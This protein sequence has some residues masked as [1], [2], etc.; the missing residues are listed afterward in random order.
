[1][2][3]ARYDE[4]GYGGKGTGSGGTPRRRLYLRGFRVAI[5]ENSD[6]YRDMRRLAWAI[7]VAVFCCRATCAA[8]EGAA[9]PSRPWTL[10]VFGP[11]RNQ[12]TDTTFHP[13]A[14]PIGEADRIRESAR[15]DAEDRRF[16]EGFKSQRL[17]FYRTDRERR[18]NS[19]I[20]RALSD[21]PLPA[22]RGRM[23]SPQAAEPLLIATPPEAA[24]TTTAENST[25]T[26]P[27]VPTPPRDT[28]QAVDEFVENAVQ[29]ITGETATPPARSAM[30]VLLVVGMF[31]VPASGI[32]FVLI[33]I[34]HLRG[35]SFLPGSIILALGGLLLWGTWSLAKTIHP[36]LLLGG[37]SSAQSANATAEGLGTL[38]SV[39]PDL[40]W[41][42]EQ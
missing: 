38:Q 36:D 12:N 26:P 41:N 24:I 40:F 39:P 16:F 42:S 9:P 35:Y 28:L 29:K 25:T 30:F 14:A 13:R 4:A 8:Q 33:G 15:Q 32:A 20:A 11:P 31:V 17:I 10:W 27:P 3:K 5:R 37:K 2:D 34:A 19:R 22:S 7:L 18:V 21:Q 23:P 6:Y 1:M